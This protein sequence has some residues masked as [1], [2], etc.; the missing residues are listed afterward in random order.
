MDTKFNSKVYF[1]QDGAQIGKRCHFHTY[2]LIYQA[3]TQMSGEALSFPPN[4]AQ[5]Q[6]AIP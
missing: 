4:V 6:K 1:T 2:M 3:V 5:D